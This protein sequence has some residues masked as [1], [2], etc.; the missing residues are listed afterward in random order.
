MAAFSA[1][2]IAF[3]GFRITRER[4]LAV[5]VWI[6]LFVAFQAVVLLVAG[7]AMGQVMSELSRQLQNGGT[8]DPQAMMAAYSRMGPAYA[9]IM[10]LS[11]LL[12]TLLQC[13]IFRAVLRPQ[14]R[15]LAGMRLGA[16]ELRVLAVGFAISLLLAFGMFAAILLV[17]AVSGGVGYAAGAAIGV[18]VAVVLGLLAVGA[19]IYVL[20][21][22]SLATPMTFAARDFRVFESW[23]ATKGRFW[24]LLGA[25]LLAFVMGMLVNVLVV[26]ISAAAIAG[27]TFA[28]AG[29][30][31]A[32]AGPAT[33]DPA[34]F[35]S[36]IAIV[37]VIF[38]G[39][40][41]ALLSIILL[42]PPAAALRAL[43]A[44]GQT[45]D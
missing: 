18:T 8:G 23:R 24:P 36:P 2:D 3:E 9:V 5:I 28:S 35:T 38:Q 27:V 25:Y 10:P 14:E 20:V 26:V 33:L 29:A 4:P 40:S 44:T 12:N 43:T 7:P 13:A 1:T 32:A 16:D 34:F 19:L 22:L 42:A 30:A 21:R 31:P 17:G 39:I 11:L 6:V 15:G 45:F 37:T 41:S